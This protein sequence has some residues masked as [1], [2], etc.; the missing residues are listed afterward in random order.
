[1]GFIFGIFAVPFVFF[2]KP[3]PRMERAPESGYEGGGSISEAQFP[4]ED[5]GPVGDRKD[6]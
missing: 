3:R 1:M 4:D 2:A 6:F 5:E